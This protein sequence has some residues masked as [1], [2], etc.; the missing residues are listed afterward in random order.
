MPKPPQP[1]TL[2]SPPSPTTIAKQELTS[3]TQILQLTHHRN[4]NQHRLAKWWKPFSVLRRNIS[5]LLAEVDALETAEKFSTGEKGGRYVRDAREVVER[6]VEFVEVWVLEKAFVA[7]S[8]VVKDLQY[9][10]LG[11]LLL[12]MLAKIKAVIRPLG[13]EK[14]EDEEEVE[15]E[16]DGPEQFTDA[17][18]DPQEKQDLGEV[19]RREELAGVL[20]EEEKDEEEVDVVLKT[21]KPKETKNEVKIASESE[22]ETQAKKRSKEEK[23]KKKR[24]RG[25]AFDDLFDSI[26]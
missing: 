11:L 15:V 16:T 6:R 5:E 22:V 13:R 2:S 20:R 10:S 14:M 12:G 17:S 21:P 19:V 9:A 26:I 18:G 25:D 4:K 7:F 3:I 8:T 1:Q 24:K 23:K